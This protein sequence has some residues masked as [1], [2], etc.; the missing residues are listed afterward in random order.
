MVGC[1]LHSVVGGGWLWTVGCS[2]LS[3]EA[4]SVDGGTPWSGGL[5]VR[6]GWLVQG[7]LGLWMVVLAALGCRGRLGGGCRGMVG[8]G[9]DIVMVKWE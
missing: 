5:V 1:W 4:G 8:G 6:G 3:G 7:R 9:G 2:W